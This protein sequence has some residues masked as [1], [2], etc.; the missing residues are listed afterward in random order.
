MRDLNINYAEQNGDHQLSGGQACKPVGEFIYKS[1]SDRESLELVAH[2]NPADSTDTMKPYG[3][4]H[5]TERRQYKFDLN[6]DPERRGFIREYKHSTLA[7]VYAV[8][9]VVVVPLSVQ[10]SKSGNAI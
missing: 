2:F 1:P 9:G 6:F 3:T 5:P 10:R 7:N 8:P 4:W